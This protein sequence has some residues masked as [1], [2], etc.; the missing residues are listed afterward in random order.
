MWLVDWIARRPALPASVQWLLFGIGNPGGRYR[1]T[2]HNAGFM[3][4]DEVSRR[5]CR[6]SRIREVDRARVC[7]GTT[8]KGYSVVC[9]KPLTFVNCS[10]ESFELLT[11]RWRLEP[12][13]CLVVVDDF[14]LPVGTLRI[15]GG[16]S[17]G[18]HRGL[19]SIAEKSGT[20]IP[21]LRVGIGPVPAGIRTV[22]FVLGRFGPEEK[23]AFGT[24][25]SKAAD[26]VL[27]C[28]EGGLNAA[29][30]SYNG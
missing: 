24:S 2:R 15:R 27:T 18:G 29:M 3:V 10:G 9:A 22:D 8:P 28:I 4:I 14:H 23:A 12:R 11:K 20:T 25:V 16:G 19:Q 6:A 26:A 13:Q 17:D 5:L 30:N 21:R 7:W 1:Y